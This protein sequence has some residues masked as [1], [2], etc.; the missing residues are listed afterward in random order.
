MKAS[1][2]DFM[3]RALRAENMTGDLEK[4]ARS[5]Y[6][7]ESGSGRNTKTSNRGARGGMQIIPD[8]FARMADPGWDIDNPEH[9]TR[10][11]LR[12]IQHLSKLA[13]GDPRLTAIGYYGGEGAIAK[14]R[15]GV[16]VSDPVNPKAPN[17]FQY[18]DEVVARAGLAPRGNTPAP[19][20]AVALAPQ[21]PQGAAPVGPPPSDQAPEDYTTMAEWLVTPPELAKLPERQ[22]PDAW[23]AFLAQVNAPAEPAEAAQAMA[24]WDA[25]APSG[26]TAPTFTVAPARAAPSFKGWKPRVI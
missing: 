14:A 17:T 11:G 21:P 3:G 24:A 20:A 19:V 22:G 8:T 7:Q 9:N 1:D 16:A 26:F 23:Q 2:L 10:A 25:P 13:G 15:K 5:I 4:V 18:G 6:A 12:Y